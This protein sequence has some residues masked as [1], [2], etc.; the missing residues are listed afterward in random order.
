MGPLVDVVGVCRSA[1]P[2]GTPSPSGRGRPRRSASGTARRGGT[3]GGRA[4][5]DDEDDDDPQVEPVEPPAGLA[6]ERLRAIRPD[7]AGRE[8]RRGTSSS[9]A[10][11][12]EGRRL[13]PGGHRDGRRRGEGRSGRPCGRR[14]ARGRR[15]TASRAR[16]APVGDDRA[17]LELAAAVQAVAWILGPGSAAGHR[18]LDRRG[19]HSR[20]SR[21]RELSPERRRTAPAPEL[22]E[23][24]ERATAQVREGDRRDA[25]RRSGSRRRSRAS[26]RSPGCRVGR[27]SSGRRTC[28]GTS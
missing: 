9:D 1:S 24:P 27:A 28:S 11:L 23:H 25:A 17:G 16:R 6:V 8:L 12:G 10:D 22:G 18:R 3:S 15:A 2:G 4:I 14:R 26:R 19:R 7:R 21:S 20:S 13:A 5:A